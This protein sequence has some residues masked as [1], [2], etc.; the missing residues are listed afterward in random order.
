MFKKNKDGMSSMQ[1]TF[2]IK[3]RLAVLI[4]FNYYIL[5]YSPDERMSNLINILLPGGLEYEPTAAYVNTV[6]HHL[7][8]PLDD[9]SHHRK[10]KYPQYIS[11]YYNNNNNISPSNSPTNNNSDSLSPSNHNTNT[12]TTTGSPINSQR[13]TPSNTPTA[14]DFESG[15]YLFEAIEQKPV[16]VVKKVNIGLINCPMFKDEYK[17]SHPYISIS[18]NA[19]VSVLKKY[20]SQIFN[21]ME[22]RVN[23]YHMN[24]TD[25]MRPEVYLSF[26]II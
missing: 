2:I 8:S 20:L 5:I 7:S 17:L 3:K 15:D 1:I 12:N 22:S 25:N 16:P 6:T 18:V 14:D 4:E 23:L 10:Q 21:C 9:K 13:H 26:F 19:T 11:P 24:H